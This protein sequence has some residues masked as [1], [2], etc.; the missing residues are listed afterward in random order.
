MCLA[1]MVSQSILRQVKKN[2]L[3]VFCEANAPITTAGIMKGPDTTAMRGV[4]K[5]AKDTNGGNMNKVVERKAEV[6]NFLRKVSGSAHKEVEEKESKKLLQKFKNLEPVY[7][8]TDHNTTI[9]CF[10]I[11]NT[12]YRVYY[13]LYE[14]T[15]VDEILPINN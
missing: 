8:S 3:V 1:P 5:F 10:K 15:I 14:H 7:I 6:L 4:V 9:K 13:N 11:G 2:K 12:F